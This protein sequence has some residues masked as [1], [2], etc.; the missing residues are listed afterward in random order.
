MREY[1][2]VGPQFWSGRTGRALKKQGPEAVIVAMYLMTC[3]H[4]T[5]LGLYYLDPSYIAAD[6]GLPLEGALKG[7]RSACEAGFCRFDEDSMVVWVVEMARYQIAGQLEVRD[8]RCKGIQREYDALPENPYLEPFFEKYGA[9]FHMTSKRSSDLPEVS[10]FQAPLKPL[11]SQEQEQEQENTLA[12]AAIHPPARDPVD[13]FSPPPA[14]AP[15][16]PKA[17]RYAALLDGWERARGKAGVFR[18][19]DPLLAAWAEAD[20]TEAELRAA[21]GKAVKRRAKARDPTP[22]NVGLVDVILPEVRRPP[23]AMSA[24]S[25]AQAARDPQAWALTASGLEAKGAQLGLALQPGETFP[26]F[27]ARVHAAAGLTEAD[28]SRLLADYGVR[29]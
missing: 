9:A 27:K 15:D 21:H 14:A 1:A 24:L 3:Q 22:V 4:A 12:A 5:M 18:P 8:N 17:A 23:A 29:V 10:P 16:C 6:T 11:R 19:D 2:K 25:Q 26:D 20:V 28:R 13:N 7:L